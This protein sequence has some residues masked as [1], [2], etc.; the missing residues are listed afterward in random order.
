MFSE[1]WDRYRH[2]IKVDEPLIVCAR[3]ENDD[4]SGG[5]RGAATELLTLGEARVKF[6]MGLRLNLT[7]GDAAPE[8]IRSLLEPFRTPRQGCPIIFRLLREGAQCDIQLPE[9]WRVKPEEDLIRTL[10]EHLPRESV[11]VIYRS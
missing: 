7:S 4:F 6:S 3:V 11:E 1:L 10:A 2:S 9:D 8:K 5:L